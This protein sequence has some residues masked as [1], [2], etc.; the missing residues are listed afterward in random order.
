MIKF[1]PVMLLLSAAA[2]AAA[3]AP[4]GNA[5]AGQRLAEAYC[6]QCHVVARAG[7]AGWTDAPAFAAIANKPGTTAESIEHSVRQIHMDM[8][9]Q[10]RDPTDA[11]DLAASIMSL[12]N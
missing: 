1:W 3:E 10:P 5:A 12:K 4:P 9:H 11:A 6:V 7:G 8:L 2:A